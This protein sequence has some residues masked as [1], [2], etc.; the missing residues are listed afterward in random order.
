MFFISL[1][2]GGGKMTFPVIWRNSNL[3][4][5]PFF[6]YGLSSRERDRRRKRGYSIPVQE[7]LRTHE[8]VYIRNI[9]RMLRT[10][11]YTHAHISAR[12]YRYVHETTD[13]A[14]VRDSFLHTLHINRSS[15]R[16]SRVLL[17]KARFHGT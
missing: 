12:S 8:R 6:V 3:A 11:T 13:R 16:K 15:L 9:Y 10:Q 2:G 4:R 17:L 7:V 1:G 14:G 5:K